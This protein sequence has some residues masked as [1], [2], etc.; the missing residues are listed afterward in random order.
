MG[1]GMM[2]CDCRWRSSM[3]ISGSFE[4]FELEFSSGM[5]DLFFL[6]LDQTCSRRRLFFTISRRSVL[7]A[8]CT[9]IFG[10]R[11][12]GRHLGNTAVALPCQ[13]RRAALR[14]GNLGSSSDHAPD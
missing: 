3:I 13:H 14:L 6:W 1:E 4:R 11:H 12:P 7:Y 9:L 5:L 10:S 2:G 8:R